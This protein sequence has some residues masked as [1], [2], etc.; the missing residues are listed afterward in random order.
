MKNNKDN[1]RKQTRLLNKTTVALL[2][3]GAAGA[4][5]VLSPSLT[6]LEK[7]ISDTNSPEVSLTYLQELERI[8]PDDPMIPY[9]KAK[10][11]YEKGNYNEVMDL[12]A[13]EIKEDPD[14]SALDTFILYLKTRVAM[15][16]SIDNKSKEQV[17]TE[18]KAELDALVNRNFSPEQIHEIVNIC[19]QI[20]DA[21]RAYDYIIKIEEPD[22][23]TLNETYSLALQ[24]GHYDKAL[25]IRK[26][27]FLNNET[28]D[29]YKELF[30]LYV[31][32][33]DKNLFASFLKEYDGKFKDD[34]NFIKAEIDTANK[35][36]LF[37]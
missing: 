23:K 25:E 11:L 7:K 21:N 18:V 9:L 17:I 10:L 24:S 26:S 36:G 34:I 31:E 35:L 14:H 13:P 1:N 37:D 4:V 16:D 19:Y 32:A 15:S 29:G 5:Y 6:A 2:A 20:S 22:Y 8:N 30:K 27:L 12:L 33:F 28:E 3:A